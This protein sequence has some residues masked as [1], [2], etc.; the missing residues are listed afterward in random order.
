[1]KVTSCCPSCSLGSDRSNAR[2]R[3][4]YIATSPVLTSFPRNSSRNQVSLTSV[5]NSPRQNNQFTP[6]YVLWFPLSLTRLR[7]TLGDF[8]GAR[9]LMRGCITNESSRRLKASQGK[10]R[11]IGIGEFPLDSLEGLPCESP[12]GSCIGLPCHALAKGNSASTMSREAMGWEWAS[13][14]LLSPRFHSVNV[15]VCMCSH[16]AWERP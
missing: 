1:M 14:L 7:G 2:S 6:F 9:R 12:G 15:F 13:E 10:D 8:L 4:E 5:T 16:N 3:R 11:C